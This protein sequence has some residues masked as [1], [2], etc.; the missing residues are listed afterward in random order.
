MSANNASS[1]H[2]D[3]NSNNADDSNIEFFPISE[4]VT[5]H[6]STGVGSPL[7]LPSSSYPSSSFSSSSS[8][9]PNKKNGRYTSSHRHHLFPTTG[10]ICLPLSLSLSSSSLSSSLK[11]L[12]RRSSPLS[13]TVDGG[14]T[15]LSIGIPPIHGAGWGAYFAG[16]V[17]SRRITERRII[18]R[19]E[20]G[21][22]DNDNDDDD[23]DNDDD[24]DDDDNNNNN[25]DDYDD[26]ES[27]KGEGLEVEKEFGIGDKGKEKRKNIKNKSKNRDDTSTDGNNWNDKSMDEKGKIR[28]LLRKRQGRKKKHGEN[29]A[30]DNNN[31]DGGD[32]EGPIFL[33]CG[34]SILS[35]G[36]DIKPGITADCSMEN[37]ACGRMPSVC[38]VFVCCVYVCV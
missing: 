19:V 4:T 36:Y 20:D 24:D 7:L 30:N 21:N 17:S 25:N 10:T 12:T 11:L 38:K 27:N 37:V 23:N 18:G 29:S 28:L 1:V 8:S 33:G 6:P 14:K 16:S 9:S 35:I 2:T 22:D 32:G 26:D 31:N 13:L 34:R 15:E 5:T 3:Y